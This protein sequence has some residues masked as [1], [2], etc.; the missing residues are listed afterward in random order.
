M[1]ATGRVA[2]PIRRRAGPTPMTRTVARLVAR[3]HNETGHDPSDQDLAKL[4]AISVSRVA[5]HRRLLAGG[6]G[7]AST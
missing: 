3:I 1:T 7:A 2:R 4:L 6:I 5:H